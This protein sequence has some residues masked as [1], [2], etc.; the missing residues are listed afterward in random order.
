MRLSDR[1]K[2]L[3]KDCIYR[4]EPLPPR[5]RLTLFPDAPEVEL[6]WQGK[7][8]EISDVVL[9]FL[10]L[11][12]V[13]AADHEAPNSQD[14]RPGPSR[15]PEAAHWTNKLIWGDNKLVL[16][17]LKNGPMRKEMEAS[18]GLK[19][20]YIDPP[21]HLGTDFSIGVQI[22]EDGSSKHP[23]MIDE[24]AYRDTWG[25][26]PDA[27]LSMMYERL[28]IMRDLLS[29]D[30]SIWVH[31]DWKVNFL[32]RAVMDE[33]FGAGAFRNEIIW[34]YTNKIPD[35]R[36]RQYTNSTDTILY[37]TR[38]DDHIFHWQYDKRDKPIKV[39][40][41]K[42]VNG[43]K[44][45][46]K[47]EQGRGLYVV[48]EERTADNVWRFPLLHA[49]PEILGYPT[50]KPEQLIQRIILTASNPGDLI[51]DFFCGSGTTLAVAEKLGRKWIGCDVGRLAIHTTRKRLI[52]V[53]RELKAKNRPC[54]DF[55]ILSTGPYERRYWMGL[56]PSVS[57]KRTGAHTSRQDGRYVDL[58]LSAYKADCLASI[59]PFH[60]KKEAAAVLIG[61]L[62]APVSQEMLE[63]AV[64]AASVHGIGE[65]D[66]LGFEF[67]TDLKPV[68]HGLARE[69]GVNVS[70]KHIPPDIFDARAVVRDQVQFYPVGY[71][72][73]LPRVLGNK[74]NVTLTSFGVF[75]RQEAPDALADKLKAGT[76]L[77]CVDHGLLV[78]VAKD[79]KG[80]MSRE[81]LT[82][83]WADWIDYW[84]VDFEYGSHPVFESDWQSFRTR[85]ARSLELTSHEHEY[86]APGPYWVAVKVIDIFGNE[87][88]SVVEVVVELSNLSIMLP[89]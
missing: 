81:V 79:K 26:G 32:M 11:E 72:E 84:A 17:S 70:L 63:E 80:K 13:N 23:V 82:K 71:V 9:P 89:S 52:G 57:A 45:Y 24:L 42:K 50:Q 53:C 25:R 69:R 28:L 27:Y 74:A 78:R 87:T 39:S 61:P 2:R 44:V 19:L 66:V 20:I 38:S 40:R 18:G 58:V 14:S 59:P 36:K 62:D 64:T 41:M 47:D 55:E 76:S 10:S 6:V 83:K 73:I 43:K 68:V 46:V 16:S 56:D 1:D 29:E 37:Y 8:T 49:Q 65:V 33:V 54:A 77:L 31:C 48:R 51:A 85:K 12:R 88:S 5:Y 75:H 30:G 21:F 67:E 7:S 4:D 60:G 35:T 22:G 3:I 34:Y 15:K 86:Q